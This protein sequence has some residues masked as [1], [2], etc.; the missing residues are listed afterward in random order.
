MNYERILDELISTALSEM[1]KEHFSEETCRQYRD[2]Y[3]RLQRL[4]LS[5]KE[6]FY[7]KALGQAFVEDC[8]Y[9]WKKGLYSNHRFFFHKR[10]ILLLERMVE[11]GKIEW[12]NC[13][14]SDAQPRN[15]DT[16]FFDEIYTGYIQML[17]DEGMKPSTICSYSRA[18]YY[19]LKYLKEKRYQSLDDIS[20][21]DVTDFFLEMCK[22][23]WDP[24]CLGSY[25]SGLK[26]LLNMSNVSRLF[27]RELP[28]HMLRKR[29]II[30]V[31][32]DEEH[33]RL[34]FYLQHAEISKRNKAFSFLALETGMRAVDIYNLK[35]NDVNWKNESIHL[36]QEKTG[37]VLNIP[38][39]ASFGNAMM[40]Y[41][42][43]ERPESDSEFFFFN[44][45][46]R[47]V[48]S[49]PI[50]VYFTF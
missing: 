45:E 21:G 17:Q 40:D 10:C 28:S 31:Y 19:F 39:R 33:A 11:T 9:V 38:L 43:E 5:R 34:L 6:Q 3:S 18:C 1:E 27:I 42:F 22:T 8:N 35:L 24:K 46:L 37:R 4:A 44:V 36:I 49:S 50:A 15:F 25:I 48:R 12:S 7:S 13:P 16:P 2:V 14:R 47:M 26:K 29:E 30:E 32:S 41:L 20:P 23:H